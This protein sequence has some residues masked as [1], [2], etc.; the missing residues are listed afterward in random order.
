MVEEKHVLTQCFFY[1][2]LP[3]F[4]QSIFENWH[5]FIQMDSPWNWLNVKHLLTT[6]ITVNRGDPMKVELAHVLDKTRYFALLTRKC[7][8]GDI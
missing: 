5:I 1:L 4:S 8:N 2:F 3:A 6:A 7:L